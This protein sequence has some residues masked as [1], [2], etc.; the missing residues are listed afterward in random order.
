M[1]AVLIRTLEHRK[2]STLKDVNVQDESLAKSLFMNDIELKLIQSRDLFL[3]P[4]AAYR[5][6]LL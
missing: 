2:Y 6:F 5:S 1:Q 3:N 4:P